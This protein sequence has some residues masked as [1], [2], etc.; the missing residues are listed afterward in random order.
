MKLPVINQFWQRSFLPSA[1]MAL[2]SALLLPL[3]SVL[4]AEDLESTHELVQAPILDL[5]A[6][7][8]LNGSD[9]VQIIVY[10]EFPNSCFTRGPARVDVDLEKMTFTVSVNALFQTGVPCTPIVTP[11]TETMT[12]P[13]SL[14]PGTYHVELSNQSDITQVDEIVIEGSTRVSKE[15][16]AAVTDVK[17]Y[18]AAPH[19]TRI[20]LLG[21]HPY[22][23]DGCMRFD[24]IKVELSDK[25]TI[26]ILPTT[27]FGDSAACQN[28]EQN[29]QFKEVI[30]LPSTL[31]T[32]R[33]LL[34]VRNLSGHWVNRIL[35]IE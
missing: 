1:V 32:G 28:P 6:P 35:N 14:P 21:R 13:E 30:K 4:F 2:C 25:Y 12:L 24:T 26:Q 7:N 3:H 29:N 17:T 27:K 16:Y 22:L 5:F 11:F 15:M 31:Q 23:F 19:E 20:E 8:R 34:R 33:Y 9:Q 18:Q 10:G